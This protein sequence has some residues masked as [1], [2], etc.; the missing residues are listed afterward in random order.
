MTFSLNSIFLSTPD[1]ILHVSDM[2]DECAYKYQAFVMM[3]KRQ[4]AKKDAGKAEDTLLELSTGASDKAQEDGK[5]TL[6]ELGDIFATE[7]AATPIVEPLKPVSL[8]PKGV[9]FC[10]IKVSLSLLHSVEQ[11]SNRDC[12]NA[13]LY[14]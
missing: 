1:D 13:C 7:S 9:W 12:M 10:I 11:S 2:M 14:L 8:M 4:A 3:R 5:S 6:D